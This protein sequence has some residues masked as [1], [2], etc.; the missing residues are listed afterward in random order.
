MRAVEE[1]IIAL[2][3]IISCTSCLE[4]QVAKL[5]VV[6]LIVVRAMCDP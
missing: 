1:G 6:R 2:H 4:K 5:S 3:T